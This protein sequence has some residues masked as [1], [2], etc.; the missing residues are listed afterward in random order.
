MNLARH[1]AVLWR[2]RRVT[3]AGLLIGIALAVLASYEISP[4]GLKP[5]GTATYTSQSQLLV[6]QPGFPEGRSV[7]PTSPALG[8]G[9]DEAEVDPD[10]LEFA[11]PNRFLALADLYTK[12]IVVGRGPEPDPEQPS[13]AQ[14]TASPLPGVSGAP[15]LPI[16]QLDTV[17][18]SPEAAQQLNTN[19][20][21][22][23]RDQIE[24]RQQ[25]NDITPPR[26]SRSPRSRRQRRARWPAGR[27]A[28]RRSS[29]CCSASS[30]PSRSRTCSRTSATA[31]KPSASTRSTTGMSS[32]RA[33]V[34]ARCTPTTS[35]PPSPTASGV[36]QAAP[37]GARSER[38]RRRT[39]GAGRFGPVPPH[40]GGVGP[41][42]LPRPRARTGGR[43]RPHGRPGHV[44]PARGSSSASSSSPTRTCCWPGGRCSGSSC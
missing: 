43:R 3:A 8:A 19:T 26:A 6:T 2:F 10:R 36:R 35:R 7:L 1:A 34:T 5:R 18:G 40:E 28:P 9:L 37:R 42:G 23:L 13:P 27:R 30:A 12:L 38:S 32:L 14:I 17:A 33:T 22:A 21:K 31:V 29:P 20:A 25:R 4:S 16:I 11:D 44:D 41:L 15:I 24:E 39:S